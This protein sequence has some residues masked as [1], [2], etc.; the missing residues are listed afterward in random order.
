MALDPILKEVRHIREEY[1][2]QFNGDVSAMMNDLRQ[3]HAQSDRESITRSPRRLKSKNVAS[4]E[5]HG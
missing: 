5:D 3:R 4:K 2:R 1:A